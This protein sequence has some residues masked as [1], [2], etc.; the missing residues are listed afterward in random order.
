VVLGAPETWTVEI[1]DA[2]GNALTT[3]TQDVDPGT[4]ASDLVE[5]LQTNLAAAALSYDVT[6]DGSRLIVTGANGGAFGL[7]ISGVANAGPEVFLKT[8]LATLQPVEFTVTKRAP[9]RLAGTTGNSVQ[10]IS[11]PDDV[12]AVL[13][14]GT[15]VTSPDLKSTN[16]PEENGE[17]IKQAIENLDEL[18]TATVTVDVTPLVEAGV[19]LD[20][21]ED[22]QTWTVEVSDASGPLAAVTKVVTDMP[23]SDLAAFL[24]GEL[25]MDSEFQALTGYT[26]SAD[27][28][29]LIV[30]APD[31]IV[32]DLEVSASDAGEEIFFG[33]DS[34]ARTW[35]LE[36]ESNDGD[37]RSRM[38]RSPTRS[39]F[40]QPDSARPVACRSSRHPTL[41]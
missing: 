11:V 5:D 25:A 31:G 36:F 2:D 4:S 3:V 22:D 26:A 14:Y 24:V 39:R 37:A 13:W 9:R 38:W 17:A 40:R 35:K 28:S 41:R 32:F 12:A 10:T 34:S 19:D 30:T 18:R 29:R 20:P 7:T 27:G 1:T 15:G 8:D 6:T 23:A 21:A 33:T 16:T